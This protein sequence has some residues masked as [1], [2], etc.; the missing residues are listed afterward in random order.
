MSDLFFAAKIADAAKRLGL[1]VAIVADAEK[2]FAKIRDGAAMVIVDLNC[3]SAK[4]LELVVRLKADP[5]TRAIPAVGFVSHVQTQ[6]RQDAVEAGFDVVVPRSVFAE[7]LPEI[8]AQ[9]IP[10]VSAK[11]GVDGKS[12]G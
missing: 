8:L 1:T 5:A 2:A 7:T 9:A 3:A 11:L 4:P 6:L 10:P 12:D